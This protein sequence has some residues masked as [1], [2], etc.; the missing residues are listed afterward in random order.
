MVEVVE[1][2]QPDEYTKNI[3]ITYN[4]MEVAEGKVYL[5]DEKEARIFREKLKK[6]VREGTPY[7]VKII[8]KNEDDALRLMKE[9]KN[10][11]L[12]KYSQVDP[13][14]VYIL[15]ERN[16]RLEKVAGD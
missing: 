13:K 14:H 4:N 16:G 15:V 1:S 3:K 9:A 6:K 11:V 10:A 2:S 7:S 12:S 8:F 5:A